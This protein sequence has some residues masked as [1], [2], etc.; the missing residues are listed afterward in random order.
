MQECRRS[1]RDPFAFLSSIPL[2]PARRGRWRGL[3]VMATVRNSV[4]TYL[5]TSHWS[6]WT[7]RWEILVSIHASKHAKLLSRVSWKR[8]GLQVRGGHPASNTLQGTFLLDCLFRFQAQIHFLP[9]S[10]SQVMTLDC[11]VGGYSIHPR[12]T[13][14][15]K[16]LGSAARMKASSLPPLPPLSLCLTRP[17]RCVNTN[18]TGL[19]DGVDNN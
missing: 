12:H 15:Q 18:T 13:Y 14:I 19:P 8:W 5:R 11:T 16:C 10:L 2:I 1:P 7:R 6:A 9:I 4:E 17:T 3:V